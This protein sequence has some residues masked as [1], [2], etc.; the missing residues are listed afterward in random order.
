[1]VKS[2]ETHPSDAALAPLGDNINRAPS[3]G[4]GNYGSGNLRGLK[5]LIV[6]DE[7]LQARAL[8]VFLRNSGAMVVGPAPTVSRGIMEIEHHDLTIAVL[9]I[10]LGA[11]LVFPLAD[12]LSDVGIPYVF[13]SAPFQDIPVRYASVRR[14]AKGNGFEHLLSEVVVEQARDRAGLTMHRFR[15][16]MTLDDALP[17]FRHMA[18]GLVD[19]RDDADHIVE[20]ALERAIEIAETGIRVENRVALVANLIE[21]VWRDQTVPHK[22]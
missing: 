8:T 5:V 1:M 9:D 2:C 10:R 4:F 18:R 19:H 21:L 11:N 7:Y 20:M 3:R 13:F 15:P 12:R 17:S 6:E 16:K 22:H 14:V